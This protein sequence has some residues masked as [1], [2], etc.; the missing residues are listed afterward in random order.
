MTGRR[1]RLDP[2]TARIRN[3]LR[4]HCRPSGAPAL[5]VA[6]SGGADSLAL[7]AAAAFLHRRGEGRFLACTVDHGLQPGSTEVAARVV[8]AGGGAGAA[9]H[10]RV[11]RG[12]FEPPRRARGGG[13]QRPVLGSRRLPRPAFSQPGTLP[14]PEAHPAQSAHADDPSDPHGAHARRSGGDSPP[15]TAAGI[16]REVPV[17]DVPAHPVRHRERAD[18]DREA[19]ARRDARRDPHSL[20]GAGPRRVGRPDERRHAL[21][22]GARPPDSRAAHRFAGAG[23]ARGPGAHSRPPA[24]GRRP[25]RRRG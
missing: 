15:G 21:H 20:R 9:H 25:P 19:P 14:D 4:A 2:A 18:R 13:S 16:G 11:D 10:E 8:D 17:R 3:A 12:R 5:V 6:V 1:P 23:S 7:A 22:P 24:G